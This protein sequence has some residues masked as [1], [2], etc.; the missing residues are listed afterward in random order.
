ME[1]KREIDGGKFDAEGNMIEGAR[2][3]LHFLNLQLNEYKKVTDMIIQTFGAD[4]T[5]TAL[6]KNRRVVVSEPVEFMTAESPV[7]AGCAMYDYRTRRQ[8]K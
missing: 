6:R 5:D 2:I 7:L 1:I 3:S 4:P 8:E